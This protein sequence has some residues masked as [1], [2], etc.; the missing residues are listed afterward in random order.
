MLAAPR[1]ECIPESPPV[2]PVWATPRDIARDLGRDLVSLK[3]TAAT[4]TSS[5]HKSSYDSPKRLFFPLRSVLPQDYSDMY[6]EDVLADPSQ[7]N[8]LGR[9]LFTDRSLVDWQLNDV[10][11]LL[12]IDKLKPEWNGVVPTVIEPGYRIIVLGLDASDQDIVR[13]L[14]DSDIYKEH[15]FDRQFRYQTAQYTVQAA[16]AR[17]A[18]PRGLT[19]PE[20]RNIIEN[21]L[22]NLACEAQ[23]RI[24]YKK[25]CSAIKR[26]RAADQQQTITLSPP[27]PSSN[28]STLLKKALLTSLSTSPDFPSKHRPHKVSLSRREKHQIWVQVQTRLYARLGLDWQPDDL[29]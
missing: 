6:T 2:S 13:A 26:Q 8:S 29:A 17:S 21:Y 19:K 23:C 28:S 1:L 16:R 22:L 27:S 10:R 24:D 18:S 9:P 11:S 7:L 3:A 5:S 15:G 14:V 4:T 12:I 25:T 20:W